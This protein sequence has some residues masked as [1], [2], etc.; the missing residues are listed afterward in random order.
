M[1]S[2]TILKTLVAAVNMSMLLGSCVVHREHHGP[3]PPK[4]HK[5]HKKPKPPR[6][7]HYH[8][9][10]DTEQDGGTY[11]AFVYQQTRDEGQVDEKRGTS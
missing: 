7:P 1:K 5:K 6:H 11:F 8:G 9:A 10:I 3:P 2:L 4:K